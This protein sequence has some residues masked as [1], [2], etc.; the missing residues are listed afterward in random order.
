MQ[1]GN[2][3]RTFAWEFLNP[4]SALLSFTVR[5]RQVQGRGVSA[6]SVPFCPCMANEASL[7]ARKE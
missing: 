3:L 1:Q 6:F 7:L 5:G 4:A 2:V